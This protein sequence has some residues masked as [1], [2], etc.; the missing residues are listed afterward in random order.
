MPAAH[1]YVFSNSYDAHTHTPSTKH[2]MNRETHSTHDA[3]RVKMPIRMKEKKKR[4]KCMQHHQLV[5][6]TRSMRCQTTTATT[7][8]NNNNARQQLSC[9]SHHIGSLCTRTVFVS[10]KYNYYV[11]F[12][13]LGACSM[14]SQCVFIQLHPITTHRIQFQLQQLLLQLNQYIVS[15]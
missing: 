8:S 3:V 12:V 15:V 2:Q 1:Y 11:L 5:E 4:V 13:L 7:N 14:H 9:Y 10:W 6:L